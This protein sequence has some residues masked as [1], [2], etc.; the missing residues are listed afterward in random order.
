MDVV[1]MHL[2]EGHPNRPGTK[3]SA[4]KAVVVHYTQNDEPGATDTMNVKYIGRKWETGKYW[5]KSKGTAVEG[6]I[7]AGSMGKGDNGLGIQFRYVS[8]HVFCDMDSVTLAI[9]TDEVAWGCGDKNYK[10]GYQRI[11]EKVF[12]RRQN[13]ETV[14]V[15]ICN[16]DVIKNSLVDWDASVANAKQWIINYLTAYNLSVDLQG[17]LTPQTVDEPPAPGTVL[18]LRHYDITG[19]LCPKPFLDHAHDWENFVKEI[20]GQ[21][22]RDERA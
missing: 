8:A 9:P 5:I 11:A 13:F 6:P 22:N 20:A 3:L 2:P 12:K 19:K 7:E 18:L 16:N 21:V 4:L 10:G 17:S 15:E 14:A 1:K